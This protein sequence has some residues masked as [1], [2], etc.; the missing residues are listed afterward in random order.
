MELKH[1]QTWKNLQTA[2]TGESKASTKYR[3]YAKKAREDG[4]EQIGNIFDETAGNEQ[5]HAEIWMKFLA[6]G[7]VPCTLQNLKEA[8]AG[9]R[10]EWTK[11]Y[12]DFAV[13]ARKEGFCELA[14]LFSRVGNIE[15]QHDKRYQ[16][17]ARN[18]ETGE[19]FCRPCKNVWICMVCG[20]V[21]YAECSPKICPVCGHSQSFTELKADNY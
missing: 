19:V 5:E 11:M 6:G 16:T 9:E 10:Y 12:A 18:I 7:E 17:L 15:K 13:T 2:F 3:I 8:A 1:S 21:T 4:Y 14:D 20:N